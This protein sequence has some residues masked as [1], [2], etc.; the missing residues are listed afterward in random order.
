M[1]NEL[2]KFNETVDILVKAYMNDT[3]KHLDCSAC[4]VGNLCG[5]ESIWKMLFMTDIS[6]GH[7][8]Q[9]PYLQGAKLSFWLDCILDQYSA[10]SKE[11]LLARATAV[12]EK[13][14]Y[15]VAELAKIEWAFEAAPSKSKDADDEEWMFNGLMA[16]VDVLAEIHGVDLEVK[17][18][19]KLMF[20]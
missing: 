5:G 11:E 17:E 18:A 9:A 4:A 13:T 19:A 16:V 12:C 6:S 15:T 3:L 20:V 1:R 8:Y 10:S 7:P 14:G 2:Q